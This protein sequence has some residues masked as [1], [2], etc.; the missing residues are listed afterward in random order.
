M[1][2]TINTN[3]ASLNAQRNLNKS[4][5]A[6]NTSLQRLSSGLRINSA[7]DDAA[8]L[9]ISNKMTSQIN[10]LNV[11][12][13]NANDGISLAQTAEGALQEATNIL[14][15]MRELS[16]QSA[17]GTNSAEERSAL[18]AE[19]IALKNELDRIATTTRFSGKMLFDGSFTASAQ[20][21]AR[22][23]ETISFSIGSFRTTELG[24]RAERAATAATITGSAAPTSLTIG[25]VTTGGTASTLVGGA[26]AQLDFDNS[27][28][29]T[30]STAVGGAAVS[31]LTFA[32][33]GGN[34]GS[35][36]V[37]GNSAAP[38]SLDISAA[39]TNNELT[40]GGGSISGTH[41]ITLGDDTYD[42]TTLI[43]E[44]NDQIGNTAGLAGRVEAVANG[45]G[46]SLQE[47][48][49]SGSFSGNALTIAGNG[50]NNIFTN[51]PTSTTGNQ[52][53][54]GSA[55]TLTVTRN[56]VT[57]TVT[58]ATT[59][60]ASVDALATAI[61]GQLTGYTV[62]NNS[63]VLTLAE[64]TGSGNGITLGGS[65]ATALFGTP[66]LTTGSAGTANTAEATFTIN[67]G[68]ANQSI[69]LDQDYTG[70]AAGLATAIQTQI[71][72]GALNGLVNVTQ[73]AGVLTLTQAGTFG[74]EALTV[75]GT[76]ADALF[77]ATPTENTGTAAVVT[78]NTAFQIA[79]NG[80]TAQ[81]ITMAEGTYTADALA[82]EINRKID[83]NADL[84]GKV[85][86]SINE[87]KLEFKTT[88]TGTA[89]SITFTAVTDNTGLT[90]L[91]FTDAQTAAG[92]AAGPGTSS[93][94]SIDI[95]TA[96]GAQSAIDI[97]D[98]AISEIDST[99]GD[100]GAIQNRMETTISNLNNIS[101]NV[102]A[103]RSRI[104]DTDF[105][106]ETASM[107]KNQILQQAGI[108][109]LSQAN[110]L[111]QQVLSLLQ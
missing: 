44:I 49:Q 111:P 86:A 90:N 103:A 32:L 11:A 101:E 8:G 29:G 24:T 71:N 9:Q 108:S 67:L 16:L 25:T 10:G 60:Y 45:S 102:A 40:I 58:L 68:T 22:A 97:I 96:A 99:R 18:N 30:P 19:S 17:N 66:T 70:N 41:T 57:Q 104:L 31:G 14:Q 43:Q 65:A 69:T 39:N 63:G 94:E 105:A 54:A 76:D 7:K 53:V 88:D 89:S 20:I 78:T 3:V 83:A 1:A 15:R 23:N 21:G 13:R 64:A 50:A 79:V 56:S 92:A 46:I 42:Q 72:A 80:G 36:S 84:K 73:N 85:R 82:D 37:L 34:A 74:G 6:L 38:T 75:D 77:G 106:A 55:Q 62:T 51:A 95:S 26:A 27:T 61:Q 98:A 47:V 12:A 59:A 81:T 33:T 100:L 109:V 107:T 48:A 28:G 91:G 4:Q 87:G 93:V 5:G 52:T 2:Q 35:A 110:S